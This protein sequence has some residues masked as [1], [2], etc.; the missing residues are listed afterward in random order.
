MKK[1]FNEMLFGV[2][3]QIRD[4]NPRKY[5]GNV[6]GHSRKSAL[7]EVGAQI[8]TIVVFE[9]TIK[10][11]FCERA[12]P[13]CIYNQCIYSMYHPGLEETSPNYILMLLAAA[14]HNL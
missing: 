13:E 9:R 14:L 1:D 12:E 5:S 7:L 2:S 3:P 11:R 4:G 10:L 6:F 8:M